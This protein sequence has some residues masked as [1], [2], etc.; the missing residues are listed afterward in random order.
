MQKQNKKQTP[1]VTDVKCTGG[2]KGK[3][4]EKEG[5]KPCSDGHCG[6]KG[7]R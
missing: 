1:T 4:T 5:E 3:K 2:E 6:S 7:C